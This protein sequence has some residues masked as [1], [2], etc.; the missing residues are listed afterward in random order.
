[1]ALFSS[2]LTLLNM[3]FL[4]SRKLFR[5]PASTSLSVLDFEFASRKMELS[6]QLSTV[7]RCADVLLRV[8]RRQFSKWSEDSLFSPG[9][10][11]RAGP[12]TP[13][14]QDTRRMGRPDA[15]SMRPG[16]SADLMLEPGPL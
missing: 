14:F 11:A 4:S 12:G 9:I 15:L 6:P 10:F 5:V 16:N 7:V 3:R 2:R 8:E 13:P 1:M